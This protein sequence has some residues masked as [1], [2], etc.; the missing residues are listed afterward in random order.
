MENLSIM[1]KEEQL[2]DIKRNQN[3]NPHPIL[4]KK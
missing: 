3:F 1:Y 2:F 4:L